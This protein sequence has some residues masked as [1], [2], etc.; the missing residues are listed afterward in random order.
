MSSTTIIRAGEHD[1]RHDLPDA[2][3]AVAQQVY[4]D[5]PFWLGEDAAA[6]RSRF[7]SAHDFF[8]QG[9]VWLGVAGQELNGQ[10]ADATTRVAGFVHPQQIIDGKPVAFFG[11]WESANLPAPNHA[12]F[13][14]LEQ[15]AKQQGAVALYGPIDF[16]TYGAYRLRL[17]DF[18][19]S[20]FPGEPCNPDYY[21]QLLE[22]LGF[23]ITCRYQ[24]RFH[25]DVK[26]LAQELQPRLQQVQNQLQ[27]QFRLS[28]LTPD[29]WLEHLDELYPLVDVIFRQNF[30][31]TPITLQ[32]FRDSCGA[33]FAQ[34]FCPRSSVLATTHNGDV[35]GFFLCYPD[36]SPLLRVANAQRIPASEIR[37]DV[38]A[39]QLPRPTLALAKTGGVHPDFRQGGLF[40]WMGMQLVTNV[41]AHYDTIAGALM[42]EDNH[43][44]RF[45]MICP[46]QRDYGLYCKP[47]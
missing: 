14:Q 7:S 35:A 8:R 1:P 36:Y 37:F 21:P 13:A 16:N 3:L 47:L 2:F 29:F 31:Y 19:Q 34:K 38:H 32:Q 25:P 30:A 27:D 20:A 11:Y 10:G 5:H 22:A 46:I 26:V 39:P 40:N 42:R 12:L 41:A 9:K 44:L 45:G 4:R 15:W 24:S 28:L 17:N 18:E 43:S 6:M 23:D 33:A